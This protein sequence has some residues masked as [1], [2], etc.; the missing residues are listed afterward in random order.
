MGNCSNLCSRIIVPNSDVPVSVPTYKQN[1]NK[2]ISKY[3][4]EPYISKIIYIQSRVRYFFRK[5]KK[6]NKYS[7]RNTNT[8]TRTTTNV[9]NSYNYS[10]SK[11]IK[12]MST[13]DQTYQKKKTTK[14]NQNSNDVK[15]NK[16]KNYG[17]K[18]KIYS[19]NIILNLWI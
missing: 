18:E 10:K 9:N 12:K 5:K 8:K 15:K 3:S 13:D 14:K 7:K 1:N 4:T 11:S 2:N 19:L 16:W 17:K 6:A